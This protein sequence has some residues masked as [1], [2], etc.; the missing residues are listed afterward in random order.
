MGTLRCGYICVALR[1]GYQGSKAARSPR[2]ASRMV[3]RACHHK[4][5]YG[6]SMGLASVG[7]FVSRLAWR[8]GEGVNAISC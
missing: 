2:L 3:L 6:L 1:Y 7:K 5:Y 4:L 8:A